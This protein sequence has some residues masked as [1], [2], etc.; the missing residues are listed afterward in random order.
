[1][2]PCVEK[3]RI[4]RLEH[5]VSNLKE[6]QAEQKIYQ[7]MILEQLSEIKA[8]V[9]RR[10]EDNPSTTQW[11]DLIKYVIGGTLFIIVGW[12]ASGVFGG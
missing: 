6:G 9:I 4:D 5:D 3:H 2:E 7:K 11:M 1:M 8:M 12:M 10:T